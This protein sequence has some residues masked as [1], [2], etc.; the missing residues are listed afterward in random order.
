[1][2]IK[3]QFEKNGFVI[4][5]NVFKDENL[6]KIR[7]LTSLIV[8][9]EHVN[10]NPLD[11]YYLRH[12]FDNGVLYDV[13]QRHPEFAP[14]VRN[15]KLL[16]AV[17]NI[18]ESSFYLYVNSF[19]Y[20]PS[21]RNNEVPFHQD[22][23]SRPTESQKLLAWIAID[24]ATKENGCLKVIPGSHSQGFRKWYRVENETHHDR[25]YIDQDEIDKAIYVELNA[26][27]VLLFSNYLIHGSDQN[28]SSKNR[29]AYRIVYKSLDDS[30]IPRG[31]PIMLRGGLPEYLAKLEKPLEETPKTN[32]KAQN[33][34]GFYSKIK[35]IIGR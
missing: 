8:E 30:V 34:S 7:E 23:L 24:D 9:K 32:L 26:G 1:M 31:T 3:K 15:E 12:R 17:E 29:R 25:I 35:K 4:L 14:F 11:N 5:K 28:N 16:D 2:E 19:L 27:D 6:E 20:K 33:S 13:F 18:F 22:F 21:D 10:Y